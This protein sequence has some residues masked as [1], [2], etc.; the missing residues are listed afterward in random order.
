MVLASGYV[1]AIQKTPSTICIH[2]YLR[3]VNSTMA[4]RIMVH[5]DMKTKTVKIDLDD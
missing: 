3:L 1:S 4:D 5:N 2:I